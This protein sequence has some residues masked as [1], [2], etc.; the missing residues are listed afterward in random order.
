MA[1]YRAWAGS[2]VDHAK[3]CPKNEFGGPSTLKKFIIYTEPT[4]K[5]ETSIY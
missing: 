2:R 1:A 5:G 3:A 4:R